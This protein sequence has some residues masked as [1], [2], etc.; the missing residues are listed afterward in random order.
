MASV[1]KKSRDKKKK[2]SCWY[3]DYT[4]ENGKRRSVKGFTDKG[5]TLRLGCKLEHEANLSKQGLLDPQIVRTAEKRRAP[6]AEHLLAYET[7]LRHNTPKHVKLTLARVRKIVNECEFK[8]ISDIDREK[9]EGCLADMQEE[10][11]IGHRTYNHY[12]QAIDA[13]CHWMIE[14]KRATS[15]PLL[16]L[17]R[18]N[19]ATD[20]RHQRR[21]LSPEEFAALVRSARTSGESIQCYTGEERARIYIISY[22]TG[23]RRKEIASLTPHSFSLDSTPPTITV[24]A[25]CSKHRK[26]DVLP[27]HTEF[28]AVLR[29]W[30]NGHPEKVLF[31]KLASRR[32]WFNGQKRPRRCRN[33]LSN[34]RRHRRLS[35]GGTTLPHYG[36]CSE[37]SLTAGS[38][39]A[40]SALRYQDDHEV[41]PHRDGRPGQGDSASWLSVDWQCFGHP[42]QSFRDICWHW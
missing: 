34:G 29:D 21:A 18:L 24:Q 8:L 30:L 12:V 33:S 37:R 11:G 39:K 17:V 23:L 28:V 2:G 10:D 16:G 9:V 7:S 13:F 35:C 38:S 36:T 14:T 41:H 19:A 22:M 25:A 15:N 6:L 42:C 31:P 32:T 40:G 27:L 1:Y 20:V 26:L 4:D 5:E 3:T